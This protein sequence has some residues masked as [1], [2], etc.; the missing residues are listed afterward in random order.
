[1]RIFSFLLMSCVGIYASIA[2]ATDITVVRQKGAES[3]PQTQA[4]AEAASTIDL[5][6]VLTYQRTRVGFRARLTSSGAYEGERT[7]E[8][9]KQCRDLGPAIA[10]VLALLEDETV[11]AVHAQPE[12]H[13]VLLPAR[14]GP[15]VTPPPPQRAAEFPKSHIFQSRLGMGLRTGFLLGLEAEAA[16]LFSAETR[17][18][19][20]QSWSWYGGVTWVAP[21]TSALGSGQ[22]SFEA[23]ASHTGF[24]FHSNNPRIEANLCTGI[25]IGR[26]TGE[27][28]GFE[29]ARSAHLPWLGA[30]LSA[31]LGIR[32]A[33]PLSV[34]L[35]AR[36]LVPFR[37]DVFV[38]EGASN[39]DASWPVGLENTI[40]LNWTP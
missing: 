40:G 24:C 39:V 15:V 28:R 21:K 2:H 11:H 22:I 37:R 23:W 4:P 30:S 36:A 31:G 20:R 12:A 38:L 10:V 7:L 32:L 29:S 6:V 5:H 13:A 1:M 35:R 17:L 27:A 34:D 19:L 8:T 14:T 25:F 16:L 26:R 3:C 18:R 33:K 9:T